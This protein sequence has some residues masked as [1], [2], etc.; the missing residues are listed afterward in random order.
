MMQAVKN[1]RLAVRQKL[2]DIY[3]QRAQY[4]F[5]EVPNTYFERYLKRFEPMAAAEPAA[6]YDAFAVKPEG[7]ATGMLIYDANGHLA[8]PHIGS[9]NEE[10]VSNTDSNAIKTKEAAYKLAY[11]DVNASGT[12]I[13]PAAVIMRW[14]VFLAELYLE[15]NDEQLFYHLRRIL[16]NSRYDNEK[17]NGFLD[18]PAQTQIWELDRLIDIAKKAGLAEKLEKEIALAQNRIAA[19]Q[20]SVDAAYLYPTAEKLTTNEHKLTSIKSAIYIKDHTGSKI[21]VFPLPQSEDLKS[22]IEWPDGTIR[23]LSPKLDLYGLK[24]KL[25]NRTILGISTR[26]KMF[27]GIHASVQDIQDGTI[28]MQVFDNLG[29][30]IEGDKDLASKPFITLS[31]G[32]FMPDFRAAVHFKD[33]SVFATAASR[34]AGI[35]IW[36]GSLVVVLII[37]TG[38]V[39]A[40]AVGKQIRLNKLKND[41]IATISH[42]L[43]T[44]LAST[45]VLVDTLLEGRYKDQQQVKEYLELAAKENARL[46]R[47]IDN[48]LTFSRMERNKT[49]FDLAPCSPAEIARD[50]AESIKTKFEKHKCAP[51]LEIAE[52]LPDINADHDAMVTV[53]VN[54]LDNACKYT[55]DDSKRVGL[56]V[57]CDDSSVCFKVEDNGIGLTRRQIRRIFDKFYQVDQTLSRKAEGCGLGLSI[58]KFIVDTHQGQIHVES[59]P[60]KGSIFTVRLPV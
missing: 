14:R 20:N 45:R 56:K 31:E 18:G 51:A 25:A 41:F 33:N 60:G 16:G 1:E 19:Y 6:I 21:Q 27:S 11:P 55:D 48:F 35:Y 2:V 17:E 50:A 9:E 13:P 26:K 52:N 7:L 29:N 53:L 28:V 5:V 4:F 8:Y 24:F 46:S 58:V 47:L 43:R 57:Y 23:K 37:L 49:A 22:K 39:A 42:E 15:T 3:T 38:A 44:P 40:K 59:K 12:S 32:K 30:C 10:P 54:L 36:T 34:Q